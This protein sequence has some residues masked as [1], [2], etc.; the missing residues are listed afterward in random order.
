MNVT[1]N[2]TIPSWRISS[3][4]VK[5]DDVAMRF[6]IRLLGT[7]EALIYESINWQSGP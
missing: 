4:V 5:L 6:L 2:N 7:G 3:I 1:W